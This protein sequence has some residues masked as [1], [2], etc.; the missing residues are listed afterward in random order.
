MSKRR[1]LRAQRAKVFTVQRPAVCASQTDRARQRTHSS[2]LANVRPLCVHAVAAA[3]KSASRSAVSIILSGVVAAE[4]GEVAILAVYQQQHARL[5]L[6]APARRQRK[7]AKTRVAGDAWCPPSPRAAQITLGHR[8]WPAAA[9]VRCSSWQLTS[10]RS[11]VGDGGGGGGGES[12]S[13]HFRRW[14]PRTRRAAVR[15]AAC[16]TQAGRTG[17]THRSLI[18]LESA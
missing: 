15:R 12:P 7:H 5:Q 9:R 8:D 11:A 4:S 10:M 17:I 2:P 6:R 13:L 18:A 3:H 14:R 16:D 1:Y